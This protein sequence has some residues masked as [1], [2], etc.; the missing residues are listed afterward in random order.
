MD[1]ESVARSSLL[2]GDGTR[3]SL[4]E[5]KTSAE[6]DFTGLDILTLSACD[7][8]SGARKGADGREVDSLGEIFL[9][10]GAGSV[11][12]TLLPVDDMS[13]PELMG[14]FYRLLYSEGRGKAEALRGAQLKV[15]RDTA[16]SAGPA[17]GTALV[18]YGIAHAARNA[19][20]AW[21]GEGYSHPYYWAPFII[22]GSWR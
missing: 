6:F 4:G 21:E 13:T 16:A 10:A 18:G 20:P 12:A 7:T 14:E 15:M 22:M 3:L 17:R 1:P 9:R 11:L 2:L 5:L 19:A 8:G